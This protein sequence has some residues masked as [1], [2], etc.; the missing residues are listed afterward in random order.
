MNAGKRGCHSPVPARGALGVRRG[1]AFKEQRSEVRGQGS[2]DAETSRGT[3]S[4]EAGQGELLFRIANGEFRIGRSGD[5]TKMIKRSRGAEERFDSTAVRQFGGTGKCGEPGA[6]GARK[7]RGAGGGRPAGSG[8]RPSG[9]CKAIHAGA[10]PG[11]R[12]SGPGVCPQLQGPRE[13]VV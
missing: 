6:R 10:H 13:A 4:R 5:G 9:S 3:P 8:P 1:A 12:A 7:C 2:G 11:N